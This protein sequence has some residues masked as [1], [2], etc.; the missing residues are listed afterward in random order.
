MEQK[1]NEKLELI[2]KIT[3]KSIV[4]S[5]AVDWEYRSMTQRLNAE[6]VNAQYI[7]VRGDE[8]GYL[9]KWI[10]R[11]LQTVGL[12]A[13]KIGCTTYRSNTYAAYYR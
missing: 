5:G 4:L 3:G 12:S 6:F 2:D 7:F 10:V 9:P 13:R 1:L 11:T 8:R